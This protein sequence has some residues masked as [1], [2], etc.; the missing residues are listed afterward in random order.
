MPIYHLLYRSAT[1]AVV[2]EAVNMPSGRLAINTT[3]ERLYFRNT[4]GTVVEPV[5]R[6]QELGLTQAQIDDLFVLASTIRA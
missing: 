6:A 4:A 1:A 5:P 2:P 3:D